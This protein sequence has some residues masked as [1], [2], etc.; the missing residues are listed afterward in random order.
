MAAALADWRTAP[1]DGRLRA[2]LGFLEKLTL[3]PEAI[4]AADAAAARRVYTTIVDGDQRLRSL[5]WITSTIRAP[6][7]GR[8]LAR[9]Y[10]DGQS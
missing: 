2:A 7:S 9:G 6:S 3:T 10:L 4:T 1:I 8:G 5:I